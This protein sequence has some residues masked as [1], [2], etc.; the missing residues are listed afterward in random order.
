[1]K[2]DSSDNQ[3]SYLAVID[4]GKTNAKVAIVDAIKLAEVE[5][6]K[7]ATPLCA[8]PLY[9]HIDVEAIWQ[10]IV[11]SLQVLNTRFPIKAIGV[12][13]H[14]ATAC[15]LDKK[16][17][18]TLPIMDYENT[19]P[20][21][22]N[23]EYA[24]LRPPFSE[25]GSPKLPVGL[26]IGAQV[27]W[28]SQTFPEQFKLT[29]H[30]LMYSQYWVYRLCGV[31]GSDVTSLGC[32]TDLI[33]PE[34]LELSSLVKSQGWESLFPEVCLPGARIGTITTEVAAATGLSIN[35]EIMAGIHDSNASLVPYLKQQSTPFSVVS[36]GTWVI[37]MSMGN[38]PVTL[39]ADRD[40]LKNINVFSSPVPTARFMGGREYDLL[41]PNNLSLFALSGSTNF[42]SETCIEAIQ[43]V[44]DKQAM[45]LPAVVT[46][47]G[48]FQGKQAQWTM[49][50]TLLS[51]D[52]R[53]IC[54]AFYLAQM[55]A[56]CLHLVDAK[57]PSYVEGPFAFNAVY[58]L[59]LRVATSR[60]LFASQ[61][62]TGTSIGTAMMYT[63]STNEINHL[64]VPVPSTLRDA[65][66][67]YTQ[68]WR[69]LAASL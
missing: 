25:T 15:L 39:D 18:L 31:L 1:M 50:E 27:F 35:T 23:E 40:M 60:P 14:G 65:L 51:N 19:E 16:G 33:N 41:K 63:T 6:C 59:M 10:F 45:L 57:G 4:L 30:L 32:H 22:L 56:H 47:S 36:T 42:V 66:R 34:T 69:T 55:T 24:S 44:I 61:S 12:T 21:Q 11:D 17:V 46:E 28:Q 26:N 3:A 8:G 53:D 43:S 68:R 5:V 54:I 9:A 58:L 2:T 48:P 37:C 52:E 7:L 64:V 38:K 62:L 67:N 49:D 20:E 29:Q 13:T